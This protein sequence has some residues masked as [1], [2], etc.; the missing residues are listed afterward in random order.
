MAMEEKEGES[1]LDEL[2]NTVAPDWEDTSS[3]PEQKAGEVKN[4]TA[5]SEKNTT[6]GNDMALQDAIAILNDLPDVDEGIVSESDN[7]E[8]DMEELF[9]LLAD[10][11]VDPN[12]EDP[13]EPEEEFR[14]VP[15]LPEEEPQ[16]VPEESEEEPQEEPQEVPEEPEEELQTVP[17][18]PEEELQEELQEV[19]EE[20]EEEFQEV[21]PLPEE[22]SQTVPE[23]EMPSLSEEPEEEP[24]EV[25]GEPEEE[26]EEP[27]MEGEA[28]APFSIDSLLSGEL[29]EEPREEPEEMPSLSEEP[30]AVDD[31]F[32]DALSAVAYSGNEEEN[33]EPEDI[34]SLDDV[35]GLPEDMEEAVNSIPVAE[36]GKA[37]QKPKVSFFKKIFGNVITDTTADEEEKE[38]QQEEEAKA[39]KAA[40]KVEKKK[41]AE[42]S[43]EE[44]A[45]LAQEKKE[46]KAQ[47]KAEQAAL[48]AEKKEEKKRLKAEREAEAAQEVVGKINPVGA[49][50]VIIFFAT[51]GVV[52]VFGSQLLERRSAL[53]NAE[54]YFANEDYMRAYNEISNVNL[55]ED[56]QALYERIRMCSQLQK[57]INSYRNYSSMGM[58]TEALDSLLKGVMFYDKNQSNAQTLQVQHAFEKLKNEIITELS[59]NYGLGESDARE[60]LAIPD[61]AEYTQRIQQ[62]AGV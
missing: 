45:Q 42:V 38:R 8:E 33:E 3:Q 25:L 53:N 39:K 40:A 57:E 4:V 30:V 6:Q 31:I 61:Q 41:Q 5:D 43:K 37:P 56:D 14:E 9:S 22:Q 26:I 44:K 60:L 62:I 28:E 59:Q 16:T 50:I 24:E 10:L 55:K 11:G 51:I 52:T 49:T 21:P 58:K 54:N 46:L 23:E 34:F 13:E 29:E 47:K 35:V 2:L 12:E 15:P 32:Q 17:E 36:P 1:Y 27:S 20:P 19:P 7:P 18:E 48:K